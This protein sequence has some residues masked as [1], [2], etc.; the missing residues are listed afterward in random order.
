MDLAGP[1]VLWIELKKSLKFWGGI[2]MKKFI[3]TALT[4]LTVA[5]VGATSAAA[6]CHGVCWSDAS[7]CRNEGYACR[8]VDADQDGFCD[9]CGGQGQCLVNCGGCEDHYVDADGDGVCDYAGTGCH[10]TDADGDGVCDLCGAQRQSST[11]SGTS[12][13][14]AP[15]GGTCRSTSH[16]CS[17]GGHHGGHHR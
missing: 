16:A 8:Y 9:G 17:T 14:S 3:I 7:H 6:A 15:A 1:I 11:S 4:V 13:A 10:F 2:L 5:A 12:A